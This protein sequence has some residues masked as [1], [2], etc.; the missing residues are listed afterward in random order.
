MEAAL[1][2]ARMA[3]IKLVVSDVDGTLVD[4]RNALDPA[5]IRAVHALRDH[6]ILF[7]LTSARPPRGLAMLLAPLQI[8]LPIFGFNGAVAMTPDL[9]VIAARYLPRDVAE[10]AVNIIRQHGL[11]PWV[12]AERDWIIVDPDG[13]HVAQE[14][15]TV[16][17]EPLAVTRLEDHLTH[18]AKIVGVGDD[19]ARMAA[20]EQALQT[21]LGDR[22]HA[23]RSQ[24]YYVDVTHPEA[25]KGRVVDFLS[26]RLGIPRDRIATIGDMPNDVMMF[27]RSGFS[28]AMGQASAE[29][30]Q[31]ASYVTGPFTEG[32]YA[33]ALTA[34]LTGKRS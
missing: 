30:K 7:T 33:Q 26:D 15:Q 13:A 21:S 23:I 27:R 4:S 3:D 10:E 20:C 9:D 16:Q 25:D 1:S 11:D 24:A 5:T 19:A 34:L 22:A 14:R 2:D 28:I 6:G 18:V 31:A 29:V 17:F 12:F 32:G 8:D